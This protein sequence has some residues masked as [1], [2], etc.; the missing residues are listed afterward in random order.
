M[1]ILSNNHLLRIDIGNYCN[2]ECPSCPRST[3]T[4]LIIK[5]IKLY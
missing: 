1:A 4:K 2:L 3:L 5:K